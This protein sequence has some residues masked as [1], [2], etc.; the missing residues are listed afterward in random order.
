MGNGQ[1]AFYAP[2]CSTVAGVPLSGIIRE[3]YIV[4]AS[5]NPGPKPLGGIFPAASVVAP[6]ADGTTSS[7]QKLGR[8]HSLLMQ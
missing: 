1:S 3:T 8:F 5:W 6:A 7:Q 2:D 4:A